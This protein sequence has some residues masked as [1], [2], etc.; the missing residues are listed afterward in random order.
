MPSLCGGRPTG[1]LCA[2]RL[3]PEMLETANDASEA[4]SARPAKGE[5]AIFLRRTGSPGLD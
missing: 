4:A 5:V 2:A 1:A 3:K